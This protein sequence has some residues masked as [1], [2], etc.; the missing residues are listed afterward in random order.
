MRLVDFKKITERE[1]K[2]WKR[3]K[4]KE[5]KSNAD[6][7]IKII[8]QKLD[9]YRLKL[10][11]K[12]LLKFLKNQK[13]PLKVLDAGC[14]E[15]YLCRKIAKLGHKVFGIDFCEKLLISAKT[16]EKKRPL[17]IKYYLNN[18]EKTPFLDSFFDII[19]SNHTLNETENPDKVL[20]EFS[21]I[22]KKKGY[23]IF[24]FFHPCF[25]LPE[26]K[27]NL[28]E[29]YFQKSKIIKKY[30]LVSGIKS[31][32]PYFNLHLPLSKWSELLFKN[33][34]LIELIEEPHPSLTTLK[35]EKWWRKNFK[36]PLFI[37]IK[38]V[39]F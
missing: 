27:K 3:K 38:T 16:Y 2:S 12:A 34:F 39:K 8:R 36:K 15:G 7:W 25:T 20:K 24:L 22:L 31:H 4:E 5:W 11:D 19:I 35:K 30:Y 26:L 37:L 17:G 18:F 10:T 28:S 29:T 14:G 21:R 23:L 9:P 13:K 1:K 6:F 32:S 33:R